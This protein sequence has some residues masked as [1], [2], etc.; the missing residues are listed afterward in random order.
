MKKLIGFAV[1]ALIVA[2]TGAVDA[3]V[4]EKKALTLEGARQVVATAIGE[5]RRLNAPGGAIAVR[6]QGPL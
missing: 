6:R 5:A 1:A 3:Q 4:A 2:M